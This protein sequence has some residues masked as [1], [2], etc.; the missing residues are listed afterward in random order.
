[1]E[2]GSHA[3]QDPTCDDSLLHSIE[4]S[5][6]DLSSLLLAQKININ[7]VNNNEKTDIEARRTFVS[8]A[9]HTEISEGILAE[10]FCIGLNI[11]S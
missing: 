9:R 1:M 8:H 2:D 4:P 5:L 6:V 3:Y 7:S 11:L 10:R